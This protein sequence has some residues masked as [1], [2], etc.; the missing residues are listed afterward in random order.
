[1]ALKTILVTGGRDFRDQK[2][3]YA[4]LDEIDRAN[5][6]T[7][8][9]HGG[10]SG[11]DTL[12]GMWAISQGVTVYL[13]PA[14]WAKYGTGAGPVRNQEMLD[15]GKPDAVVAFPGGRGTADMVRRAKAAGVPVIEPLTASQQEG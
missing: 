12:A 14:D 10:A 8:L 15:R 3:V 4:A 9:I 5:G 13:H 6:I 11:A 2:A 1:M 7:G